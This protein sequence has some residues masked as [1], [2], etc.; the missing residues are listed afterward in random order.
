V[1][2]LLSLVVVVAFAAGATALAAAQTS[3]TPAPEKK[4]DKSEGTKTDKKMAAKS[5][6]GTVKSATPDSVVVAGKEKGKEAEWT[7]GID[8]KTTVKKGGKAA[9]ASDLKPG[10][11]VQVRYMDHEGKAMAQA[12]NIRGAS[13]EKKSEM[14]KDDTMKKDETKT[15]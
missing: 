4:M 13:G 2:K 10:D 7:F 1:K 9:T 15:K 8:S 14:K 11:S 12:I 6:S 5:A 3:T